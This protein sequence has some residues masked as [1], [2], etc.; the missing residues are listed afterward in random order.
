[1]MSPHYSSEDNFLLMREK[2]NR[3]RNNLYKLV[4]DG[5]E[6]DTEVQILRDVFGNDRRGTNIEKKPVPPSEA[7]PRRFGTPIQEK[8][9]RGKP[10]RVEEE[11]VD[12]NRFKTLR[13]SIKEINNTRYE[14]PSR[15][16]LEK[17]EILPDKKAPILTQHEEPRPTAVPQYQSLS[18]PL[19]N[20]LLLR[21]LNDKDKEIEQL[22]KQILSLKRDKQKLITKSYDDE[23]ESLTLQRVHEREI[24]QL[25]RNWQRRYDQQDRK[26]E[27]EIKGLNLKHER[28]IKHI[29]SQLKN[30]GNSMLMKETVQDLLRKMMFLKGEY[31]KVVAKLEDLKFVNGYLKLSLDRQSTNSLD[32]RGVHEY[33]NVDSN[34]EESTTNLINGYIKGGDVVH[35]S[36]L[37]G[38]IELDS[39][40]NFLINSK[41]MN[42]SFQGMN[43][44]QK[45]K[46]VAQLVLF[47]VKLQKAI[48][49]D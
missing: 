30:N 49:R 11:D 4:E 48:S 21:K 34:D 25:D 1:M 41:P 44:L 35:D 8:V 32:G 15:V 19:T 17:E 38:G 3:L 10:V 9:Q 45:F 46:V 42:S 12:Q 5:N 36:D 13:D 27:E 39:T 14:L 28:Q 6:D 31:S 20:N 23:A 16:K 18:S 26:H 40:T 2:N 37:I 24:E 33:K 43:A 47:T 22:N 7:L 29:E